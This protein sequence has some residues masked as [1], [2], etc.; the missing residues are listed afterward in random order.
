MSIKRIRFVSY[1]G[2]LI[3]FLI[4]S[5]D[6]IIWLFLK[7]LPNSIIFR[8][9]KFKIPPVPFFYKIKNSSRFVNKIRNCLCLKQQ[10]KVYF[11]SCL[12]LTLTGK[13]LCDLFSIQNE[14]HI[15]MLIYSDKKK[16]PHSWLVDPEDKI[17]ITMK[18]VDDSICVL[19]LYEF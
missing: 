8:L 13:L 17:E 12:S 15:G 14:V 4:F 5:I 18:M 2:K 1:K 3:Y 7:L 19:E 10:N 16:V 11:S 6:L 9:T